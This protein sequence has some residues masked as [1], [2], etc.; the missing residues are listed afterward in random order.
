MA[1][2]WQDEFVEIFD[3]IYN[4]EVSVSLFNEAVRNAVSC[5]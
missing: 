1:T 2:A 4:K 5:F 3:E